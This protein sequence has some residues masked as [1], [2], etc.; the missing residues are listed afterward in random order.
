MG[1]STVSRGVAARLGLPYLDTGS[2]Y[3]AAT[4]AVLDAEVDVDDEAGILDVL[5]QHTID[6]DADEG[7]LLDGRSVSVQVRSDQ[8]TSSVSAVSAHPAVRQRIVEGQRNWVRRHGGSAVVEGRDIGTVVFPDTPV[9]V[10]LTA[11]PEVRAARRAGDA[12][13]A[14]H[15]IEEIAGKLAARDRADSARKASPMKPADDAHIVDTSDLTIDEVITCVI[16]IATPFL[17]T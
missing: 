2:T 8:V 6:Y 7:I 11:R 16:E 3:R 5:A 1:K 14:D 12:E 9:K 17:D 13:A 10:F 15:S 4:V